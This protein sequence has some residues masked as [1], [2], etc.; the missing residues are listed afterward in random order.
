[1]NKRAGEKISYD[2]VI[3]L[4]SNY[5]LGHRGNTFFDVTVTGQWSSPQPV[6]SFVL[7]SIDRRKDLYLAQFKSEKSLIVLG[8]LVGLTS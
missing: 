4:A 2:L 6:F 8:F 1:M 5:D 3:A 7:R